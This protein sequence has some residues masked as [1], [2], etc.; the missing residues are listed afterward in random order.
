[1]IIWFD[2]HNSPHINMF[3]KL[4]RDLQAE[5]EIIITA[6][7]LANTVDLLEL[8]GLKYTIVGQHYGANTL[9]KMIGYPIRVRDLYTFLKHRSVDLAV[10]QSSFYS[11]LVA[12]LLGTPSIYLNDNEHALGNVPSFLF[13]DI[14]LLPECLSLERVRW[15]GARATKLRHFP[16]IKE[17][18]YLWSF[19]DQFMSRRF[20]KAAR[21]GP[22]AVYIRPEPW[23][24]QYYKADINFMDNLLLGL[25]DHVQLTVLPRGRVQGEHYK[26]RKF[27]GIRVID[28]ALDLMDIALDCDLFIGAGG[29]MTRE[30]A[31]LGIPTI[32]IYQAKLL[33]VDR[34]L[35]QNG[36]ME[37][38][39]DLDAA[40]ALKIFDLASLRAPNSELLDKGKAAYELLRSTILEHRTRRH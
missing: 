35:L 9:A 4:M 23:T 34:Y 39:P 5:N 13:A 30:M 22:R 14:I 21:R 37:H 7:E 6:R 15:Q 38:R 1:M 19:A 18:M 25:R 10:S 20:D 16:G 33:E 27:A 2:L 12:R 24:A 8:H 40:T 3:H 28:T 17:G 32:S 11:P 29:T 31:V 26:D 36:C